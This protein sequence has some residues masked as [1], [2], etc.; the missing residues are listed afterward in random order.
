MRN[1]SGRRSVTR[2]AAVGCLLAGL[3]S[4]P[5]PLGQAQPAVETLDVEGSDGRWKL[6][7]NNPRFDRPQDARVAPFLGR[8]GL[9]LR[10]NTHV[11]LADTDFTSGTIEFDVAPTDAGHFAAVMFRRT[12]FQNQEN[13]YL[14]PFKSGEFDAVQ[15]APRINGSTWQLCPEFQTG[16]ELPRK[17]WTHIRIEVN[18]MRMEL[19]VNDGVEPALQ[20]SR[21]RGL[22]PQGAVGFWARVNNEPDTWAAVLSRIRVTP[23]PALDT[24]AA[25]EPVESTGLIRQWQVSDTFQTADGTVATIPPGTG[26]QSAETEESGL[27]N[28]NRLLGR[29]GRGRW[30]ALA[31]TSIEAEREYLARMDIGYSDEVTV[32]LNGRPLYS[33]INSWQ[34]RYPGYLGHVALGNDTVFLPLRVGTNELVLAVSDDLRFGWGFVARLPDAEA[35]PDTER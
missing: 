4:A 6:I 2:L 11:V 23:A 12:A 22:S 18:G 21:L 28:L 9:W 31:R 32:F 29:P 1:T 25:E 30:T 14:R 10:N 34:S 13:V 7:I 19:F 33:G 35:T 26:W 16:A 20:V 5:P 8:E 24:P 27:V 3:N 15:Y 17:E